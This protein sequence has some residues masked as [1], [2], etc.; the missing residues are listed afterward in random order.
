MQVGCLTN[1]WGEKWL[2]N[3]LYCPGL[4]TAEI[5]DPPKWGRGLWLL[6][7]THA[8]RRATIPWPL[9]ERSTKKQSKQPRSPWPQAAGQEMAEHWVLESSKGAVRAASMACQ[10]A[11]CTG[12][13]SS[14]EKGPELLTAAC[15]HSSLP[16]WCLWAFQE[17]QGSLGEPPGLKGLHWIPGS[18]CF[19]TTDLGGNFF[20]LGI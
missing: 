9:A 17:Q 19:L 8:G 4:V 16:S 11:G 13:W 3:T 20:V 7:S 10:V 12:T 1:S 2:R 14:R 18:S 5:Y 15:P 6:E